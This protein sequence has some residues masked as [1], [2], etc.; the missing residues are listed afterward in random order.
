MESSDHQSRKPIRVISP[1]RPAQSP[2]RLTQDARLPPPPSGGIAPPGNPPL[3][4]RR[5]AK[6]LVAL[7]AGVGAVVVGGP[8]VYAMMPPP[9]TQPAAPAHPQTQERVALRDMVTITAHATSSWATPPAE[10]KMVDSQVIVVSS[11]HREPGGPPRMTII[12]DAPLDAHGEQLLSEIERMA[13]QQPGSSARVP[14]GKGGLTVTVVVAGAVAGLKLLQ[15]VALKLMETYT[16]IF[17]WEDGPEKVT[18]KRLGR[19]KNAL[20]EIERMRGPK[21]VVP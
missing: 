18:W 2:N 3:G 8:A 14:D 16:Q 21:I 19:P 4:T 15:P 12:L 6:A 1:Y 20:R 9:V 5:L 7:G 10:A 11:E 13:G 17:T